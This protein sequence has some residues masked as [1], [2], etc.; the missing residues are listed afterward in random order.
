M[1]LYQ[2]A[3][4][5]KKRFNFRIATNHFT[6]FTMFARSQKLEGITSQVFD[7]S[8]KP[9]GKH[10]PFFDLESTSLEN[11]KNNLKKI[12]RKYGLS[13]I[14]ITSDNNKTFRGWC[15]SIVTF[16]TFLKILIDCKS[17]VDYGFLLYTFKRKEATL[18]LSR[19]EGRPLQNVIDVI[20][21]FE[22]SF[23]KLFRHVIYVTG[24]EKQGTTLN[25]G[26]D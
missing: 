24:C 3:N 19:K 25:L 11:I 7:G 10:Y 5:N 15:F 21:S 8:G 13:N 9:T 22:V 20:E 16:E 17:I 12:Q 2:L 18:R 23:P 1:T 14:Y 4:L 6:F 26:V